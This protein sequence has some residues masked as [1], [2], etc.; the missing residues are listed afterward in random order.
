MITTTVSKGSEIIF[1]HVLK[2][3]IEENPLFMLKSFDYEGRGFGGDQ[4]MARTS[5]I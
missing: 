4:G 5:G 3:L 2:N 1:N